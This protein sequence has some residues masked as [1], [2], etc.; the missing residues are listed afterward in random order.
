MQ[1]V[2]QIFKKEKFVSILCLF[3]AITMLSSGSIY[4]ASSPTIV[5]IDPMKVTVTQNEPFKL[6]A[7]VPA[8]MSTFTM[9][10]VPITWIETKVSTSKLGK[11]TYTG[12]VKN[13]KEKVILTLNVVPRIPKIDYIENKNIELFLNDSYSL[14]SVLSAHRDDNTFVEVAVTWLSPLPDLTKKGTYEVKGTVENYKQPIVYTL[15]V[16]SDFTVLSTST[17]F[18][19]WGYFPISFSKPLSQ[20]QSSTTVRLLDSNGVIIPIQSVAPGTTSKTTLI[21]TPGRALSKNQTYTLIIPKDTVVSATG[22]LFDRE[23]VF[24]V[25]Y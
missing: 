12:R 15:T 18:T 16:K 4:A 2:L 9:K 6:P 17:N 13:Y 7:T 22:E 8:Y 1:S 10:Q 25:S 20:N 14:P 24:T 23:L 19:Q 11:F 3:I 21:I 5:S